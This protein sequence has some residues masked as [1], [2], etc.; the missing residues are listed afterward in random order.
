MYSLAFVSLFLV[1]FISPKHDW[2]QKI[3]QKW[4]LG[5][6]ETN[7]HVFP[8]LSETIFC[9]ISRLFHNSRQK[10]LHWESLL[11]NHLRFMLAWNVFSSEPGSRFWFLCSIG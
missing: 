10:Q 9:S 5:G 8:D 4:T 6:L 7:R 2:N 1:I 3:E 11:Y